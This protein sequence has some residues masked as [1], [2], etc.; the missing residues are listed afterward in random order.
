MRKD[1]CKSNNFTE[2]MIILQVLLSS[3]KPCS[4]RQNVRIRYQNIPHIHE[5]D[6]WHPDHLTHINPLLAKWPVWVKSNLLIH[7]VTVC[8]ITQRPNFFFFSQ[9]CGGRRGASHREQWSSCSSASTGCAL[10]CGF[11]RLRAFLFFYFF[12]Y[13]EI[14][15]SGFL[16]NLKII[17]KAVI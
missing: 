14:L 13:S 10:T 8:S 11:M 3:Y 5:R 17:T 15:L 16:V 6:L 2:Q 1:L 9:H 12:Y 7:I 4:M